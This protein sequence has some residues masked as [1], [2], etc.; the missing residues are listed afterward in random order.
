[1]RKRRILATLFT[2]A[3]LIAGCGETPPA[4]DAPDLVMSPK[5]DSGGGGN[6][7]DMAAPQIDM[8]MGPDLL[9]PPDLTPGPDLATPPCGNTAN[10]CGP[11]GN[12]VDCS[13]APT[14]RACVNMACG[15]NTEQDCPMG[16]ACDPNTR[17]CTAKCAGPIA[18]GGQTLLT[19]NGG[20][21]DGVNCVAGADNMA[22]GGNG[23]RCVTCGGGTPTCANG[24][25]TPTCAPGG[26]GGAACGMGF[27]CG[28]QNTCLAVGTNSCGLAGA[29]CV[30][31]AKDPSG[32]VCNANAGKCGC[33]KTADCPMGRSCT[34]GVCTDTCDAMNPCNGGCCN[35]PQGQNTGKCSAGNLPD[36]CATAAVCTSCIANMK[37][38]ACITL[39]NTVTCGC[40]TSADCPV[41]QACNA[42]TKT[43]GTACDAMNPC[44]GGCCNVPNGMTAGTCNAGT[45]VGTCGNN[46][47]LCQSCTTLF[48]QGKGGNQCIAGMN[49]GSCGCNVNA[50]CPIGN[51]CN[52]QKVCTSACNP[53]MPACNGGCC[54]A[55]QG[56]TCQPGTA[57]TACGGNGACVDCSSSMTGKVCIAQGL[58]CGCN[59][60]ADCPANLAC[61]L[62][63]KACENV[64]G[65]ANH[66]ACNGGCCSAAKC[67][68]GNA[69]NACGSNGVACIDCTNNAA[70]KAC[71]MVNNAVACGC[72]A[73]ADCPA[74]TACNLTTKKCEA[75][76]GDANHT[77]CS[78]GCCSIAQGQMTG[79]CVAGTQNTACG[80]GGKACV[81][82]KNGTPTCTAGACTNTCGN[83]GNG[84]CD[85]GNC[86][87]MATKKCVAGNA[88][89]TCGYS[90]VCVNCVPSQ[91]GSKCETAIN[92]NGPWFCGCDAA[93]DCPKADPVNGTGGLAC[94]VTAHNCTTACGVQGITT[95][96]NGGCCQFANGVGVC[97]AGNATQTCGVTGGLCSNCTL[98]CAQTA[99]CTNGSCG[100]C[101]GTGTNCQ[102]NA[103]C[104]TNTCT[105]GRCACIA[106]QQPC[107]GGN[108][109]LCCQIAGQNP[110]CGGAN[111]VCCL[112]T[113]SFCNNNNQC[114][115]GTCNN[116]RCT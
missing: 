20:C 9:P 89:T 115:S 61:N 16:N 82:C 42:T 54:S 23:G 88:Q 39:N 97:R 70:G 95:L 33:T 105:N 74:N 3:L 72:N 34:A 101:A 40:A 4:T 83:V 7:D 50:D 93:A 109:A 106:Q 91:T 110:T 100:C 49:G 58:R 36:Q 80:T 13:N 63:T 37:G 15:C 103:Q 38:G 104:C 26:M 12:C 99:T 19:C 67:A 62:T 69:G 81:A 25:C 86:C 32:P 68:S 53:M 2:G 6:G 84:T 21:C 31:C 56:N 29:A 55:A 35:I 45:Q 59:T 14:G 48:M 65:D 8:A 11:P 94:D 28:P 73:A 43:C 52:G 112:P 75:T 10:N 5:P 92:A 17:Q 87:D 64:C 71:L 85:A 27:C 107:V 60:S 1:M 47:G 114:C 46:G 90:G 44:N 98:N 77:D 79:T 108:A 18:D 66:T 30:D 111:T 76:C 57:N 113:N 24:A 96:C 116:G 22:C 41:G 102:N 78:A 51:S